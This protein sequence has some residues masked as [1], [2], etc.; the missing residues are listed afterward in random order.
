MT[1][2]SSLNFSGPLLQVMVIRHPKCPPT[3]QGHQGD[4]RGDSRGLGKCLWSVHQGL[5]PALG[6]VGEAATV[7]VIFP[8]TA[9]PISREP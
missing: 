3:S 6:R 8:A 1:L 2:G 9:L 5:G 4:Q 7:V